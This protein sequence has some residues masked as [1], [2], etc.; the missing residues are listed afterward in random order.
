MCGRSAVAYAPVTVAEHTLE[1]RLTLL[2]LMLAAL[3]VTV[4]APFGCIGSGT[5]PGAGSGT[6]GRA[7]DARRQFPLDQLPTSTIEVHEQPIRVWLA[8]T[9]ATQ[10][11]GLM[12]VP[13]EEIADDQGM[14]FVFP[15]EAYRGFW[16]FNTITPLD[17]AFARTDGTI[18]KVWTMPAL[19][20]QTFPSIE[21]AM[22]AL[23]MK[24]GAFGRLG[25]REG[26]TLSI[27]ADVFKTQP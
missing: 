27:P 7:S 14:L 11:E 24:A 19:T 1:S 23:E 3:L 13:G 2:A 8:T 25:I 4:G 6:S 17:I 9:E 20:I 18:V 10:Q 5:T 22:F 15:D 26:D 21:P 16:M 12:F